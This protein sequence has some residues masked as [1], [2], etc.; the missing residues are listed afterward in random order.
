MWLLSKDNKNTLKQL[1][2]MKIWPWKDQ[3][4]GSSLLG[5]CTLVGTI[6]AITHSF[7]D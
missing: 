1:K 3:A 6:F 5:S 2:N 7:I 4:E